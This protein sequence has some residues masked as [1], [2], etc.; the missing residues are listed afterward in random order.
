MLAALGL[1]VWGHWRTGLRPDAHSYGAV[2]YAIVGLQ[3]VYAA[4]LVAMALFTLAKS[5]VGRLD[6]V[7]RVTFDNTML[8]WHY[9]TAQALLG[10][11]LDQFFPWVA[12]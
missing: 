8:F 4:T 6:G 3:G 7:R 1:D 11:A 5:L 2:D 12:G 9:S 10:L